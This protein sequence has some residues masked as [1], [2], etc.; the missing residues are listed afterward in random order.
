MTA[1]V[2]LLTSLSSPMVLS[3][4]IWPSGCMPCSRLQGRWGGLVSKGLG[5]SGK[6]N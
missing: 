4:G 1:V 6:S 2:R 5:R 3:L